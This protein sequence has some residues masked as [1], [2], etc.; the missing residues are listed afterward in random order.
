MQKAVDSRPVR[1]IVLLLAVLGAACL[2]APVGAFE[3]NDPA[4]FAQWAHRKMRV[5]QVWDYTTGNESIVI[6]AVDTGVDGSSPDI[7]PALVGGWDFTTGDVHQ[8][9]THGHG[10]VVASQLIAR[11]N[12]GFAMAGLCWRCRLMP[13]RVTREGWAESP[14]IAAG[15]RWAVDHGARIVTISFSRTTGPDAAERSAVAYARSR[16]VLVVASAGNDASGVI[17]YPAGYPGV[18]AVTGTDENDQLYPWAA[19]GDWITLAAPGCQ[20]IISQHHG[21]GNLCGTSLTAPAV[22]GVAALLLSVNPTLTPDQLE[23]ALRS[24]AAPVAGI[25]G[26]RVDAFAALMAIGL[27][28]FNPPPVLAPP[29]PTAP[30]VT[31]PAAPA[32]TQPVSPPTAVIAAT[33][34]SRVRYQNHVR[35]DVGTVRSSRRLLLDLAGGRV[36]LTFTSPAARECTLTFASPDNI[37][38]GM[39]RS[40]REISLVTSVRRGRYAV[41]INC[42]TRKP[43][44]YTLGIAANQRVLR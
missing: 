27:P 31:T 23:W 39:P 5:N 36:G 19:R 43:K 30:T 35:I 17:G 41:E 34:R 28:A 21:W 13:V 4:W 40:R 15:V 6:A 24:T 32:A 2:A 16:G 11:G 12:N 44:R 37:L 1:G 33:R 18:L 20:M 25:N 42:Q 29:A 9:D 22:A 8:V 10:T 38:I 3:P 7:G 26:G 14:A